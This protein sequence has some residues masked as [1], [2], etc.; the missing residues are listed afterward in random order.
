[1]RCYHCTLV[2]MLVCIDCVPLRW[3]RAQLLGEIAKGSWGLCRASVDE[4]LTA[5][6][7]RWAKLQSSARLAYAPVSEMTEE[8]IRRATQ[9]MEAFHV[10]AAAAVAA[11]GSTRD[12]DATTA[13]EDDR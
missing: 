5:E 2:S 4:L 1:M 11:S 9:Q 13:V 6:P 12:D 8:Y 10:Q 7:S 3:T